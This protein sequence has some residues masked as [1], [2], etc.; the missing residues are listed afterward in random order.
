MK[1]ASQSGMTRISDDQHD[2]LKRV[3]SGAI[4]DAMNMHPDY[5]TEKGRRSMESSLKKRLVGQ[6]GSLIKGEGRIRPA[7]SEV[8]GAMSEA[9]WFGGFC[10][11]LKAVLGVH[12]R[13]AK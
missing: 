4:R 1:R 2:K 5:L 9:S 13:T 11:K 12:S 7:S 3:V 10:A 8:S 6:L